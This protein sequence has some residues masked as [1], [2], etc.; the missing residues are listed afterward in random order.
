MKKVKY[1]LSAILLAIC[2]MVPAF[3]LVGCKKHY[4]VSISIAE[5]LGDVTTVDQL[6]S[7]KRSLVGT[8]ELNEGS[9]FE[10]S[11]VPATG[12]QIKYIKVDG[13]DIE[14][15]ISESAY[16]R[17]A[18]IARPLLTESI[19]ANH[20]IVVAFEKRTYFLTFAFGSNASNVLKDTNE[21]PIK[22]GGVYLTKLNVILTNIADG[23]FYSYDPDL[24]NTSIT[25]NENISKDM[26]LITALSEAE[27]RTLLGV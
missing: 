23:N 5:G 20:S 21:T 13:E 15:T 12:Y 19:G 26:L 16:D 1:I 10:Y 25:G 3:A 24:G 6:T 7:Q 14:Y 9:R 8:H 17:G 2:V 4:Q 27:L 11:V 18:Y 22:V